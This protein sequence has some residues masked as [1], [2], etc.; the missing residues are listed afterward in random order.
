MSWKVALA[1]LGSIVIA[2]AIIAGAIAW[3]NA[4]KERCVTSAVQAG[5]TQENAKFLCYYARRR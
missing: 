5:Y 1:I 3:E 4:Y 2:F